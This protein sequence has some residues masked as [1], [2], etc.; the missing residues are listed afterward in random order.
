MRGKFKAKDYPSVILPMIMIRRIECVL[1]E[2]RKEL[3][4]IV[5]V[6]TPNLDEET[7]QKEARFVKLPSLFLTEPIGR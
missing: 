6:E 5:K 4:E 3:A 2:K 7:L 1:I